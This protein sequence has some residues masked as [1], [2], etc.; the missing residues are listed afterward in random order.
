M[1]APISAAY[2]MTS[3]LSLNFPGK[4]P[5][6][7]KSIGR[8]KGAAA[9]EES[10]KSFSQLKKAAALKSFEERRFFLPVPGHNFL[11]LVKMFFMKTTAF[12]GSGT[13]MRRKK[14]QENGL[15]FFALAAA[16][17]WKTA[18]PVLPLSL[19]K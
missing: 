5:A 14:N 18:F 1:R 2:L 3:A 8:K 15:I 19:A 11:A 12:G 4:K 16:R 10:R 13:S 9:G 6:G 7:D 17:E